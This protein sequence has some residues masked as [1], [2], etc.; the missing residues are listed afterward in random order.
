MGHFLEISFVY[1]VELKVWNFLYRLLVFDFSFWFKGT[2]ALVEQ[3]SIFPIVTP[4]SWHIFKTP[5]VFRIFD[6]ALNLAQIFENVHFDNR[7]CWNWK[8][9]FPK[10]ITGIAIYTFLERNSKKVTRPFRNQH[11]LLSSILNAGNLPQPQRVHQPRL[12]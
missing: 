1:S 3:Y 6:F 2:L 5:N 9:V 12:H 10:S 7:Y 4:I 11:H 8:S